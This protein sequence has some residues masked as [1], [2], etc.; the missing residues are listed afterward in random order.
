MAVYFIDE[1]KSRPKQPKGANKKVQTPTLQKGQPIGLSPIP[2]NY[3]IETTEPFDKDA[4]HLN[5]TDQEIN[6]LKQFVKSRTARANVKG[7]TQKFDWTPESK[8]SLGDGEYRTY[9]VRV[10][11]GQKAYLCRIYAKNEQSDLDDKEIKAVTD[12]AEILNK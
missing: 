12:F 6:Q 9:C 8:K 3:G 5:L 4:K 7:F 11:K 10:V 1:A 2:Q